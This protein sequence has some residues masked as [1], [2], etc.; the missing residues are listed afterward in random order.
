[1]LQTAQ[2]AA[3]NNKRSI[4]KQIRLF[5]KILS[6]LMKSLLNYAWKTSLVFE[7]RPIGKSPIWDSWGIKTR[8]KLIQLILFH[9]HW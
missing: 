5:K 2:L 3:S 6:G 1:M 8:E 9:H 4:F 7:K